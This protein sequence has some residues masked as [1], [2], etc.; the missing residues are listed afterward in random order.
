MKESN[1]RQEK[2]TDLKNRDFTYLECRNKRTM[3]KRFDSY[4]SESQVY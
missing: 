1:N 4:T 3:F 2:R